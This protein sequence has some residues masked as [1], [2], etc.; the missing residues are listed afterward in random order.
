MALTAPDR[1]VRVSCTRS[2]KPGTLAWLLLS[3]PMVWLLS[4]RSNF[5][6]LDVMTRAVVDGSNCPA[7]LVPLVTTLLE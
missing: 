5:A 7:A 6:P 3:E 2:W 4:F 1:L